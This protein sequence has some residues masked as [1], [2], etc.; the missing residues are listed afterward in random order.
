MENRPVVY[1]AHGK[2]GIPWGS[3]IQRLADVARSHGFQVESPDLRA[4]ADPDLRTRELLERVTPT[5][6]RLV[7]A[8]SSM[9]AYN[10]IMASRRLRPLGLFLL[11]PAVYL[12]G[13]GEQNPVPHAAK[14]VV[15]HGWHDEVVPV[16]NA[17][18]FSRTHCL[19]LHLVVG[20][21]RLMANLPFIETA[22]SWLLKAVLAL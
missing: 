9:G 15:V 5:H 11:A 2:E 6:S 7:L 10:A 17:I 21:H 22:F 18:R 4:I 19:P 3:K 14:M 16:E 20:D 13:Y 12:P 1:F 8:G